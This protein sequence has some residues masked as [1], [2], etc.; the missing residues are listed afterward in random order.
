[1]SWLLLLLPVRF[2][3]QKNQTLGTPKKKQLS[4]GQSAELGVHS[5]LPLLVGTSPPPRPA[6]HGAKNHRA[7]TFDHSW[8]TFVPLTVIDSVPHALAFFWNLPRTN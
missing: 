2:V 1:M 4:D 8:P 5:F 7:K 3:F 6:A